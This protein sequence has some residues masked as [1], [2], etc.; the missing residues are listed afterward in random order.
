MARDWGEGKGGKLV[1]IQRIIFYGVLAWPALPM[2]RISP[3][4]GENAPERYET[5]SYSFDR[6]K[7]EIL[8]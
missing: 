4:C 7:S 3:D 1:S 5:Q 2:K 6:I 8:I